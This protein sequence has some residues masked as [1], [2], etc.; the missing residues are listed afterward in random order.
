MTMTFMIGACFL[1][2]CTAGLSVEKKTLNKADLKLTTTAVPAGS[3][4]TS[5]NTTFHVAGGASPYIWTITAGKL[6]AG[7]RLSASDG[8]LTGTPRSVGTFQFTLQVNSSM[9]AGPA[10]KSFSVV[11]KPSSTAVL[12]QILGDT[13]SAGVLNGP[14]SQTLTANGGR[15]PY[16]WAISSGSLPAGVSLEPTGQITGTPRQPGTFPIVVTVQDAG[17]TVQTVA[18]AFDIVVVP[19][20]KPVPM[21]IVTSSLTRGVV[22]THYIQALAAT[23]GTAPY[24]WSIS[25]AELPSGLS[26]I[27][28]RGQIDGTPTRTGTF[29]VQVTVQDSS[30][31]RQKATKTLNIAIVPFVPSVEIVTGSLEAAVVNTHYSQVLAAAGGTGPYSW[32]ISSAELPSGLSL[33]PSR[34]QIDGIP[35]RAGTFPVQLT[36]QD[37]SPNRQKATKTLNIAIAPSA[38][39]VEIVTGSLASGAVKANYLQ[40]LSATGGKAPY[41]WSVTSGLLPSGL[42]LVGELGKIN[43]TPTQ[44]GTFSVGILVRD[45]SVPPQTASQTY[46]INVGQ[47]SPKSEG[48]PVASCQ[49]LA[50]TGATYTL[51]NDIS[52]SA[53]CFN[54]QAN[55]VTIQL[56][57]HTITYSN[58][59]T[60]PKY[61]V[62][63]VYGAA[64]WDPNF[65]ADGIAAGNTTGGNWNNLSIVGPGTITQGNCLDPS[66]I[67]IGSNAV[68]L[69][70]GGGDG[71]SVSQ[72]T[73]NICADSTQAIFA[74]ANGAGVS[75]HDNIVKDMV[76][77]AHKRSYFQGVAFLCN[78]CFNDH[79]ASSNVYNNTITGGPQGCIMWNNPDTN[80]YNNICSH[81]NP[82]AVLSTPTGT[83]LCESNPYS[84]PRL[85]LPIDLGTQC[86]NDFGLYARGIGGSIFG[87]TIT[88]L[89]GRGIFV[90]HGSGMLVHDNRVSGAR[91]L[92]NN[93]EYNGCEIGGAYGLQF[94]DNGNDETAYHN[95]ISVLSNLCSASALRVTDSETY[96]NISHDN[97]YV[98]AR[99]VG[100]PSN[101]LGFISNQTN[102]AYGVSLDGTGGINPLQ[103]TSQ[104]DSFTADSAMMYFDW[105]GPHN[106]TLFISPTFR[107][108]ANA[109]PNFFHFA[110]FRNGAG[111]VDVHVRDAS[112][113]PGVDPTDV[114]L[115]AQGPNNKAASL[116]IEWTLKLTVQNQSGNPI[117]GARVTYSD[118]LGR[119][120][121][122]A[123]TDFTGQALCTLIEYRLNND[124]GA[125]Q[126]ETR[127]PFSYKLS[128]PGCMVLTGSESIIGTVSETKTL[129]GC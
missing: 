80:L 68:H 6:P 8:T 38:T 129:A 46:S 23:G 105:A 93:A 31:N 99:A 30:P 117:R 22:N 87:N 52:S 78:G 97:I 83:N 59:I 13:L 118:A 65:T 49:I 26:L 51:Q 109:D 64:V 20:P 126:I 102:C 77:T 103:F 15:V 115:P 43:G 107:K 88:P 106:Q 100:S 76:V 35:T 113:S 75:I 32:S 4:G 79:G 45:S 116:Y 70:Q 7:L 98:S 17:P 11:I 66:N 82:T 127:N 29:P 104:N 85:T 73:F 18:K 128:A 27:P 120:E 69:G 1:N 2:G 58:S 119:S 67:R 12:M 81:G 37:S 40:N 24:F 44:S 48:V 19:S 86:T 14:Y 47:L 62:F 55:D 90:G 124:S 121:C 53:S 122:E 92:P 50:T 28:D 72:V 114:L 84:D 9:S 95:T 89:E 63:G 54:V 112:F 57:G 3:F 125:N 71:L 123:A 25:S 42:S 34:G 101:C 96:G 21:D 56:N 108:G 39:P 111:T 91:E 41:L 5:Y 36:V 33:M 16:V 94:D 110:V 60:P 74:D 61:A 10:S